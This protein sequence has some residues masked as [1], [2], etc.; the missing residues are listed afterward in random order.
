[1]C[2]PFICGE[3]VQ[4]K[5]FIGRD[6]EI[7]RLEDWIDKG[8]SAVIV[9]DPR[10]G[11]TSLLKY[12]TATQRSRNL[13]ND[14]KSKLWFQYIDFQCTNKDCKP[15]DFWRIAITKLYETVFKCD[16]ACAVSKIYQECLW[17]NF[18]VSDS[19]ANFLEK[20]GAA[21]WRLVL[22][23]DEFDV[24]LER[25]GLSNGVFLGSLRALA[26]NYNS[27]AVVVSAR[28]SLLQLSA[29]TAEYT[30]GSPFFNSFNEIC[31]EPFSVDS[32]HDLLN[33]AGGR[34][35][36]SDH[37]YLI[38]LTGGYP[39]LLQVAAYE[40]WE[41]Y[42][43]LPDDAFNRWRKVKDRLYDVVALMFNDMWRLWSPEM[44]IAFIAVALPQMTLDRTE[45]NKQNL[46]RDFRRLNLKSELR[47]LKKRGLIVEGSQHGDWQVRSLVSLWWLADQVS[48]EVR[49]GVSC[50][51][52]LQKQRVDRFL[53]RSQ[54]EKW[55][56]I[57]R[58][59]GEVLK[60]GART[61]VESTAKSFGGVVMQP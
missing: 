22:L 53:T 40:L 36:E 61:L 33:W 12:L 58:F 26:T 21:G 5:H 18:A 59:V 50:R 24:V 4:Y 28:K 47:D 60:D 25:P 11:K 34:F 3:P 27:L 44:R 23:L 15:S 37:Q 17:E 10:I 19:L 8:S 20:L 42:I 13:S 43:E 32:C 38:D 9:G 30:S 35:T 6:N 1:M 52:W 16:P 49:D 7:R 54:K 29:A 48:Q 14:L 55:G 31:L 46:L 57:L 39:H 41:A 2:N 51:E 56:E 45:L